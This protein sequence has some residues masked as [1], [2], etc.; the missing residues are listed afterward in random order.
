M[1]SLL[2]PILASVLALGYGAWLIGVGLKSPAG[3]ERMQAI[4][5]AIQEGAKAYL[6][7]QYRTVAVVAVLVFVI[8][9]LL[10]DMYTALGFAVGA[11]FLWSAWDFC[12]SRF[13][14]V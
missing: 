14:M 10:I 12:P 8:L 11:V 13:S 2:F 4:A 1:S 7:R 9:W 5:R 3:D 6:T